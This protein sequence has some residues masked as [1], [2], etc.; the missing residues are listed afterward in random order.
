MSWIDIFEIIIKPIDKYKDYKKFKQKVSELLKEV[1]DVI[2][3]S[4]TRIL[5]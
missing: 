4:K 3:I 2:S 1:G 5:D